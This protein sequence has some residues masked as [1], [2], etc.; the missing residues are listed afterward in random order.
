MALRVFAMLLA[1]AT[2]TQSGPELLWSEKTG[3]KVLDL[4]SGILMVFFFAAFLLPF[5]TDFGLMELLGTF[6][7]KVFRRVFRL[8]GRSAIDAMA[9][10]LAAAAVG[11]LITSQQYESGFYSRREAS[12]IATNFSIVSIPFALLIANTIGIGH[13]TLFFPYY[14]TVG[15]AGL[16]C[17][18]VVPRLPPLKSIPDSY[19]EG[20][21]KKISEDVP[22]DVSLFRWGWR[23]A[24]ERAER[25]PGP[26]ALAR[27]S[28]A[29]VLDIWFS[30]TPGVI[31]VGGLGLMIA[32]YTPV[33]RYLS[34]PLVPVLELL[35]IPEAAAAAP[36]LL[37]GFLEMFLPAVIASGIESELTRFGV[38]V[39]IVR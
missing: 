17:A 18:W 25:A 12:V 10:W 30:L 28:A 14:A 39:R 16:V 11:I 15:V 7:R 38:H 5:L 27:N 1:W 24:T 22:D 29:N 8:P 33:M 4:A 37:V 32:E 36:A 31:A 13:R 3:G 2:V 19:F 21:G 26:K 20:V 34:Y 6:L 23:Q 35:R 9:S